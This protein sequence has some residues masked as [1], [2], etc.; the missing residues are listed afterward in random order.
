MNWEE[1]RSPPCLSYHQALEHHSGSTFLPPSSLE[2]PGTK[3]SKKPAHMQVVRH[4][5]APSTTCL[6][7]VYKGWSDNHQAVD[8]S[9]AYQREVLCVCQRSPNKQGLM[10][11]TLECESALE[12][13]GAILIKPGAGRTTV[14]VSSTD[15]YRK[16]RR[17]EARVA[18]PFE[19][20]PTLPS[21]FCGAQTE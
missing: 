4:I 15:L 11:P 6:H 3:P 10:A 18:M 2:T 7:V 19:A 8:I 17:G 16:P 1:E 12:T 20:S 21:Q 14:N 5:M 9:P 13:E